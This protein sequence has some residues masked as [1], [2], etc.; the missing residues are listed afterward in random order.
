MSLIHLNCCVSATIVENTLKITMKVKNKT[1]EEFKT[2]PK[3]TF[4]LIPFI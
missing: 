2:L 1:T 4:I 3:K